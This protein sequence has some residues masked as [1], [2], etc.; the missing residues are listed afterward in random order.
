ME[1]GGI[2]NM[3]ALPEK[4][5]SMGIYRM[6]LKE[7]YSGNVNVTVWRVLRKLLYLKVYKLRIDQGIDGDGSL[8]ALKCKR[9]RNTRH[10]VIFGIPM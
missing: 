4:S 1:T 6:F 10:R 5:L 9:F 8:Y 7:L 3:L 2:S